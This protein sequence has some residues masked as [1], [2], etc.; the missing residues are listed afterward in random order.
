MSTHQARKTLLIV[1]I[2]S[3]RYSPAGSSASSPSKC[4]TVEALFG[5]K[6]LDQCI[7]TSLLVIPP[8]LG[9]I[10]G[11]YVATSHLQQKRLLQNLEAKHGE[12]HDEEK[13]KTKQ[14]ALNED[15]ISGIIPSASIMNALDI[16][17]TSVD[18]LVQISLY[19]PSSRALVPTNTVDSTFNAR[20][21]PRGREREREGERG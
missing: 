11:I 19:I 2:A 16:S 10:T 5:L 9:L 1:V 13:E 12:C 14:T 20:R 6:Y 8:A 4:L 7:L 18:N 21:T 3:K 15:S 17:S